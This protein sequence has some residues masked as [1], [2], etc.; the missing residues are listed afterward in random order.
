LGRRAELCPERI[1]LWDAARGLAPITYGEWNARVNQT[2]RFLRDTL[3]VR[4]GDRVAV[5]AMNDPAVLDLWFAT[6]KLGAL[7]APL[8]W[9]LAA[10]ELSAALADVEPAAVIHGP[11]F[12]ARAGGVRWVSF[13]ELARRAD[14][15]AGRFDAEEVTPADPWILCGTGGST[16]TPKAAVLSYAAVAANAV[17]TAATWGLTA[18]DVALLNAPLF[19]TGGMNVL[20]A[21]LVFAGGASVIARSFD[22]DQVFDLVRDR[23]ITLLFG[24]PAM[25]L[26]LQG[27][28]RWAGAEFSSL[29]FAISGGAPC[30]PEIFQKFWDKGVD[31]KTGYGLTEAGPNNF[32]LPPEQVKRKPGSVGI[33]LLQIDARIVD[34]KGEPAEAEE[35]GELLLRGPHLASG[36]WR[37]PE[38]TAAAFRDG[39]LWT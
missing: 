13:E 23:R 25:F 39:W 29:R 33:P 11:D 30:P 16:G 7:F 15:P 34:E 3:G 19:H 10:E 4:R 21:P 14:M 17:N 2:A 1:A 28:R 38:E 18:T 9:R 27:H 20:T 37:R 5:L 12:A 22:P 8:N 6:G 31:F 24:V 26:A 35:V 32:W 36:Y